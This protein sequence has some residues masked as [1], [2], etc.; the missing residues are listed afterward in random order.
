[1][2]LE[3]LNDGLPEGWRIALLNEVSDINMGQ[4]PPSST[5]NIEGD[6]LPFFQGKAEFGLFYPE[7]KKWCTKP[8]KIAQKDDVLISVRAP[9]GPTNLAPI[10][11][12]IGRGLAAIKPLGDM[13]SKYLLYYL[14]N[15]ETDIDVLGTGS[16]FK[17]ISGKILRSIQV[18][19]APP[20]QQR[21]IVTE[22]E[23]QFS[24][25]DEAV[26]NL[27]CVKANLK[28]YKAAVLKAAV[29]GKLNGED[30]SKWKSTLLGKITTTIRN[31]YSKKPDAEF[32]TR[33]FRISAVRPLEL[34]LEDVRYLSCPI[35]EYSKHVVTEG[36]V[37]FTRYNGNPELVGVCAV[38][39]KGCPATVHPDKLIRVS[40]PK[41][42]LLP[43]ML[44]LLATSG[45]G[46]EYIKSKIRTTAGQSGISGGDLK[47]LPLRIPSLEVQQKIIDEVK[48]RLSIVAETETQVDDNLLRA[49]GLR[50]SILKKAFIG[51]LV[52]T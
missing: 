18:P 14:R 31:G 20:E 50:Q 40:V 26:A 23:K 35:E 43:G 16:T 17:A 10:E 8:S 46:R 1:M 39:P 51:K 2:S 30:S 25:L 34:Y 41:E 36:N 12:C 44:A 42:I 6:G 29:Q 33:I 19:V 32:G 11:C 52:A 49:E 15:I 9:V 21:R 27:K 4:S 47:A 28:R 48:R 13:P 3:I 45:E 5:Y 37:L 7:A 22:I 38:V 24:R